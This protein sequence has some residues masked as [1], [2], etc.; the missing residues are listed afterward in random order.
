MDPLQPGLTVPQSPQA[1]LPFGIPQGCPVAWQVKGQRG[2]RQGPSS[3]VS[4]KGRRPALETHAGCRDGD[5]QAGRSL[6]QMASVQGGGGGDFKEMF[7]LSKQG[8]GAQGAA[9]EQGSG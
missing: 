1:T 6:Y 9:A 7:S 3:S 2:E 5:D 8:E 4:A